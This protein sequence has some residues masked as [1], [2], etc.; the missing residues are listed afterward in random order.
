MTR[1]SDSDASRSPSDLPEGAEAVAHY[2]ADIT[3][4]LETMA[5]GAHLELLAYLLAMARAEAETLARGGP[6]GR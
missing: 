6:R 1:L 5:R 2:L 3:S 4:Q